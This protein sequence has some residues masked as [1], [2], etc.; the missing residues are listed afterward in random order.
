MRKH[1][2]GKVM[3]GGRHEKRLRSLGEK[4][5]IEEFHASLLLVYNY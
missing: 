2:P 5:T 4:K 3:D 1:L